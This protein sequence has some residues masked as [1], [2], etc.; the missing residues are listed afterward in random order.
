M[1]LDRDGVINV[2]HGYIHTS[3]QTT[4][5][6]GIFGVC[7]LAR[8]H[9]ML[10]V[11][12]TNQAGIARGYYSADQFLDYTAWMHDEFRARGVPIAA[13]YYCPHHPEY[14]E[15]LD[16]KACLCRKPK[17]GMLLAAS[18]DLG[19]ELRK[20]VLLG[21]RQSDLDA[22]NSAGLSGALLW[23]DSNAAREWLL[24]QISSKEL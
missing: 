12:V 10:V 6:P 13:T 3:Q 19:I 4:W 24:Q 23:C 9:D 11:V 15:G 7:E 14:G 8:D 17:P 1:F 5:I 16:S 21:D 20:S 22:A 2:D 18:A